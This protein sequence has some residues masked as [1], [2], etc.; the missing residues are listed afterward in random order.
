MVVEDDPEGRWTLREVKMGVVL[1][2]VL[3]LHFSIYP[4][5]M[6]SETQFRNNTGTQGMVLRM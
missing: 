4:V 2:I 1:T 6:L 3:C 5:K